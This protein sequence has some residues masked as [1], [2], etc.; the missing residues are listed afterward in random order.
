MSEG[1]A[2]RAARLVEAYL[3]RRRIDPESAP[4]LRMRARITEHLRRGGDDSG[5]ERIAADII[6]RDRELAAVRDL[7]LARVAAELKAKTR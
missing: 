6:G 7:Y 2:A 5:A 4:R 1:F 3:E